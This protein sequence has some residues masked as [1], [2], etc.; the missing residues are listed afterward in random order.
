MDLGLAIQYVKDKYV[1]DAVYKTK[2]ALLINPFANISVN[3][4]DNEMLLC[5]PCQ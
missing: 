5:I 2:M 4:C 3:M 1:Y